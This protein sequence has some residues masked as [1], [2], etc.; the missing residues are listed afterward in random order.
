LAVAELEETR[1][2]TL[3]QLARGLLG[4][5]DGEDPGGIDAVLAHAAHE[6]LDQHR[7]LATARVGREQQRARPVRDRGL[8]GGRERTLAG[9]IGAATAAVERVDVEE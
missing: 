9:A 7:G 5:G 2:Q 6:A 4:E 3:A 1:A 8:L